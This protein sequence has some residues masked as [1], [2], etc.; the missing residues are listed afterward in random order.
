ME[1]RRKDGGFLG[2]PIGMGFEF[3]VSHP[4]DWALLTIS[5]NLTSISG[6]APLQ[7][8]LYG[9][10]AGPNAATLISS[11]DAPGFFAAGTNTWT[12]PAPI[13][14]DS[15]GTYFIRVFTTGINAN[16]GLAR[17]AEPVA[18]PSGLST[19]MVGSCGIGKGRDHRERGVF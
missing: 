17:T 12:A 14:L 6:T 5:F 9:S 16:Y 18:G 3:T 4:D 10:P 1:K 11:L 19:D 2:Q 8:E 7:V 15:G 13:N